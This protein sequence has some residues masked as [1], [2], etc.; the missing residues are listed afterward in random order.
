M[1]MDIDESVRS[2]FGGS[3]ER[4]KGSGAGDNKYV[5]NLE[6]QNTKRCH[7]TS[8]IWLNKSNH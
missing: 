6:A 3:C 5:I 2:D 7:L 4:P 1:P 8:C